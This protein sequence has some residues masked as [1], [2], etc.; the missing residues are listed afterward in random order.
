VSPRPPRGS[1]LAPLLARRARLVWRVE[2]VY[3]QRHRPAAPRAASRPPCLRALCSGAWGAT[4]RRVPPPRPRFRS[5]ATSPAVTPLAG[6][7]AQL[8][9]APAAAAAAEGSC[10]GHRPCRGCPPS[11]RRFEAPGCLPRCCCRRCCPLR[12]YTQRR[13]GGSQLLPTALLSPQAAAAAAA[14]PTPKGSS[15]SSSS[16][17]A[18]SPSPPRAQRSLVIVHNPKVYMRLPIN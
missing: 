3:I 14:A 1:T 15:S 13:P 7:F 4:P 16:S 8:S 9:P 2:L 18:S 6:S 12:G 11:L 17:S 10:P 5:L